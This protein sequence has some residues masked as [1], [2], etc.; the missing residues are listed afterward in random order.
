[1][2]DDPDPELPLDAELDR[3]LAER[4]VISST[5]MPDGWTEQVFGCGHSA[6]YITAV[7]APY[8]APCTD[9][10]IKALRLLQGQKKA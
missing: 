10:V 4:V 5:R 8:P 6:L 9:C 3:L 7:G 1:M 2:S